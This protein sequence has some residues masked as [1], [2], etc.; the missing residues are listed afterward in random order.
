MRVKV[1]RLKMMM[2]SGMKISNFKNKKA[3]SSRSLAYV[4]NL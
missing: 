4:Y 3:S 1:K 2:M